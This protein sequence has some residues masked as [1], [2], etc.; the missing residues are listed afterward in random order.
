MS[1]IGRPR[2]VIGSTGSSGRFI[3]RSNSRV[4]NALFGKASSGGFQ[5][6][7]VAAGALSTS[8]SMKVKKA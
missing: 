5:A 7:S 1:K 4:V 8:R 6:R 2:D 3:V